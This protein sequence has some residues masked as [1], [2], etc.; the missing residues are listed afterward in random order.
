MIPLSYDQ[1]QQLE[2]PCIAVDMAQVQRNIQ[3]MQDIAE[4]SRCLL[5]PHIKTHKSTEIARMQLS[6][7]ACGITCAT[8][9]EAEVMAAG[10]IQDIFIAYPLIGAHKLIRAE[11]LCRGVKRLILAADSFAGARELSRLAVA[12]GLILEVRLEIDTG[13]GRTGI[14]MDKLAET[15]QEILRLEGLDIT[16]IYTFKSLV[17]HGQPTKDAGLA[18]AE[19]AG[20]M[21]E[22]AEQLR[23]MG[24]SIRDIS[25]GSTP[26]AAACAA[27]GGINEIRPGTYVYYDR[28]TYLEGACTEEETAAAVY[29]T[30]V[31]TPEPSLAVVDGGSKTFA[32]DVVLGKPPF[33][34]DTYAF[35]PEHPHLILERMNE[36]HGIL[37]TRQGPT[38]LAVGDVVMLIPLHICTAVN[39]QDKFYAIKNDEIIR[40]PVDARGRSV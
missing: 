18:G 12:A 32:G 3:K 39:L 28:M 40:M 36:E 22:A 26:T 8:V 37:R 9:S 14:P 16:G 4:R 30:V 23:R 15:G 11:Q 25:A 31:S 6:A 20:M 24:F 27:G 29:A 13:A 7:G 10:G 21:A 5:R 38:G 2:T 19:E 1:M 17:Y 35:L 33:Y 34:F